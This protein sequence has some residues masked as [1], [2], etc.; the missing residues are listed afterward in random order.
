[1]KSK[2]DD[3]LMTKYLLGELTEDEQR[4]LEEHFLTDDQSYEQLLALEDELMYEYLQ[5]ELSP[6]QS[7]RFSRR[8]LNS[9]EGRQ[10]E[11]FAR[12]LAEKAVAYAPQRSRQASSIFSLL[13]PLWQSLQSLFSLPSP[14]LRLAYVTAA[15]T[16]VVGFS[17]LLFEN[18]LKSRTMQQEQPV[19]ELHRQSLVRE[20]S[21]TPSATPLPA[22]APKIELEE[23]RRESSPLSS[24]AQM[25]KRRQTPTFIALALTPGLLRDVA[26][27]RRVI[28]KPGIDELQ[29]ELAV[30]LAD[31]YSS[32]KPVLKTVE[33][34]E[35]A[36]SHP[37]LRLNPTP[38][39]KVVV[40]RIPASI[41]R[42]G[43]YVLTL[44]GERSAGQFEEIDDYYFSVIKE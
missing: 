1:M 40:M 20:Q 17:W 10:K 9:P 12:L 30:R 42:S 33:G 13:S 2:V 28:I 37:V 8:F 23:L 25:E 35:I 15:A 6:S 29:L 41:F 5:G 4:R 26:G 14:G 43:D 11:A 16:V 19:A 32:F 24:S 7:E 39:G 21:Q 27:I 38:S 3:A 22:P 31:E 34:T 36:V 44:N 18:V